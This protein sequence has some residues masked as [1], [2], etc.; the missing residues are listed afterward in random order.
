MASS[1]ENVALLLPLTDTAISDCRQHISKYPDI[2]PAIPA[3]LTRHVNGLMCTEIEQVITRLI[4]ERIGKGCN[5]TATS[6]FMKSMGKSYVRNAK[7]SEIRDTIKNLGIEYQEKL[8]LLLEQ[9][10]GQDGIDKLGITVGKRN[11]NAH[12]DPPDITFR[13][14]EDVFSIAAR[15]VEAVRLTLES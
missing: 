2:D 15:V 7:V 12:K 8:N 5:D 4:Q 9:T 1:P 6:N 13:E 14:L 11:E 3:Y 10:V